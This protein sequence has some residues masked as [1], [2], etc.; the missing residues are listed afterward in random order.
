M[1]YLTTLAAFVA[2][3]VSALAAPPVPRLAKEFDFVEPSGHHILLSSLKGKVVIVQGLLTTC[4]HC[5]AYSQVLTKLQGEYGPRGFQAMG[6]AYDVD[7][8]TAQNYVT[9]YHV[10]FP[11][12]YAP[13]DTMISFLGF[14]VLDRFTVPQVMIIDR[15]GMIQTQSPAMSDGLLQQEPNVRMWI[16]KLLGPAPAGSAKGAPA[17][18][19][20]P[21][22]S[23]KPAESTKKP[24]S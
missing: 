1:R 24:T 20:A 9:Q 8:A 22:S 16:E 6:I 13:E 4:P 21:T 7:A 14:S 5:Q 23:A 15:K 10:G 18:K 12:G 19:S 17:T 3:G 2:L 11:V